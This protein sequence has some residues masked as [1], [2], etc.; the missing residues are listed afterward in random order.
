MEEFIKIEGTEYEISSYGNLKDKNGKVRAPIKPKSSNGY[1]AYYLH[2]IRINGKQTTRA[3][4][5]LM[6][7]AFKKSEVIK[8]PETLGLRRKGKLGRPSK[9]VM[10]KRIHRDIKQV[11]FID[12]NRENLFVD[13]LKSADKDLKKRFKQWYK[14]KYSNV[15]YTGES[16]IIFI[17]KNT[18]PRNKADNG[19]VI[20]FLKGNE[21]ALW[22]LLNKY[23]EMHK[24]HLQIYLKRNV[25][26]GK[27]RKESTFQLDD[28]ITDCQIKIIGKVKK[29][30]FDGI[31]FKAWSCAVM[32]SYLQRHFFIQ[33]EKSKWL[34]D[35]TESFIN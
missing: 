26:Q 34:R 20:D 3:A 35:K 9:G 31:A 28:F 32:K 30:R 17:Q 14:P 29:G 15:F 4:H 7:N 16:L 33:K 6:F 5:V 21:A 22:N 19:I 18:T 25:N 12:G 27:K 1:E 23:R 2:R 10:S 8:T 11:R 13:N 24:K